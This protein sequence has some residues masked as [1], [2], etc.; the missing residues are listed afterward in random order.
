MPLKPSTTTT[1]T[2]GHRHRGSIVGAAGSFSNKS[3]QSKLSVDLLTMSMKKS[4]VSLKDDD[5]KTK[6]S[7]SSLNSPNQIGAQIESLRKA[8]PSPFYA[9]KLDSSA[10]IELSAADLNS[11]MS[12]RKHFTDS[13]FEEE[14]EVPLDW[15]PEN[16]KSFSLYKMIGK[17][18]FSKVYLSRRKVDGKV[19][20]IKSMRKD[21]IVRMRQ[22]SV[23]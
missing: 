16:L 4:N 21:N 14:E 23:L 17:G 8:S 3:E 10:S 22:V 20:A 18:A 6:G 1:S 15:K 5:A 12:D 7:Y 2:P 13:G 9:N 19:F 11:S